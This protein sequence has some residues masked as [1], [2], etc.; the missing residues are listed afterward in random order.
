MSDAFQDHYPDR[1][2]HC[3]GCGRL[4]ADGLHVKSLWDGDETVATV[5]P[6][7]AHV[8]IPGFV[9]GGFIASAID[10]HSTGSAAAAAHR[11][12]GKTLGDGEL[13]RFLTA[14]LKVEY[15]KP[16]PLGPPLELRSRIL[17]VKGRKVTVAT[18]L[19]ANG[20]VTARGEAV[21]VQVPQSWEPA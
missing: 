6:R 1:W 2:S 17:E 15:L 12:S 7:A 3:Y 14:T 9:Y 16:T 11:A 5:V 8:A 4:N 18:E 20:V 13:P 10:C 21:L 19:S